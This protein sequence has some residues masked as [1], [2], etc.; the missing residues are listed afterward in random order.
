MQAAVAIQKVKL[1]L[2][3][4]NAFELKEG[5]QLQECSFPTNDS[6]N[7]SC[8]GIVRTYDDMIAGVTEKISALMREQMRYSLSLRDLKSVIQGDSTSLIDPPSYSKQESA[9]SPTFR[10]ESSTSAL[11]FPEFESRFR[12][13]EM[14]S[15]L[16]DS[17]HSSIKSYV[18]PIVQEVRNHIEKRSEEMVQMRKAVITSFE[19]LG[20]TDDIRSVDAI[21]ASNYLVDIAV[22]TGSCITEMKLILDPTGENSGKVRLSSI[23]SNIKTKLGE[24]EDAKKDA[25]DL[26]YALAGPNKSISEMSLFSSVYNHRLLKKKKPARPEFVREDPLYMARV[27]YDKQ[28]IN[29]DSEKSEFL[30]LS[31]Y[32]LN[33]ENVKVFRKAIEERKLQ[34]QQ[35]SHGITV[36]LSLMGDT[37][38][39]SK[40]DTNTLVLRLI[41]TAKDVHDAIVLG[42]NTIAEEWIAKRNSITVSN[43]E[44][45]T[46]NNSTKI[47]GESIMHEDGEKECGG[48]K[49]STSRLDDMPFLA[50]LTADLVH[51]LRSMHDNYEAM[52]Q[53]NECM[54]KKLQFLLDDDKTEVLEDHLERACAHI[55]SLDTKQHALSEELVNSKA[56]LQKS[57]QLVES[58]RGELGTLQNQLTHTQQNII[59]MEENCVRLRMILSEN[60]A[61]ATI[62]SDHTKEFEELSTSRIRSG[63]LH[64]TQV[65]MSECTLLQS[66]LVDNHTE[67]VNED[68]VSD[69]NEDILLSSIQRCSKYVRSSVGLLGAEQNLHL[70]TEDKLQD[71]QRRLELAMA[72]ESRLEEL[73][74]ELRQ[75]LEAEKENAIQQMRAQLQGQQREAEKRLQYAQNVS[76]ETQ[77]NLKERIKSLKGKVR[78]EEQL[79][80]IAETTT[81]DLLEQ[82]NAKAEETVELKAHLEDAEKR[83]RE[84]ESSLAVLEE[85]NTMMQVSATERNTFY[86]CRYTELLE[87]LVVTEQEI[88]SLRTALNAAFTERASV[89]ALRTQDEIKLEELRNVVERAK[90]RLLH[91]LM[92]PNVSLANT[93]IEV[94]DVFLKEFVKVNEKASRK[95]II[96][97]SVG[98]ITESDIVNM[99]KGFSTVLRVFQKLDLL[100]LEDVIIPEDQADAIAEYIN[101]SVERTSELNNGK[102]LLINS[103]QFCQLGYSTVQFSTPLGVLVQSI[104]DQKDEAVQQCVELREHY[105]AI[106]DEIEQLRE[107]M[108]LNNDH[109]RDVE[110]LEHSIG[111]MREIV[112]RKQ[113]A[114]EIVERH[115]SEMQLLIDTRFASL[116]RYAVERENVVN[117]I[118]QLHHFLRHRLREQS[119]SKNID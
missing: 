61:F 48:D 70:D 26:L 6:N 91:C 66:L 79:R 15:T 12:A 57:E 35:M 43:S 22:D 56:H 46:H 73:L 31:S 81:I 82:L 63:S 69:E 77:K 83:R 93:L 94:V 2:Q 102:A 18:E 95:D 44:V 84:A 37:A 96:Y 45:S 97:Y 38:D 103:M 11:G 117:H 99:A 41:Q 98:T 13:M 5:H 114:D 85:I 65:L 113:N 92:S 1:V 54:S 8:D 86:D 4:H 59:F 88:A 28:L 109:N 25:G 49:I 50:K 72:E 76:E 111:R 112:Q 53:E 78:D 23:L 9:L 62:I 89:D 24:V 29:E 40:V 17:F 52:K 67:P 100:P 90:K 47:S 87:K 55:A 119:Q 36:A 19:A 116:S 80:K 106:C 115:T 7:L 20:G 104:L 21:K 27:I 60:I 30:H 58:L 110:E 71:T 34:F 75:R 51:A 42:Q 74:K 33:Y 64:A 105:N 10:N 3:N 107:M 108:K 101:W 68:K 39:L 118:Q 16:N 32:E 14:E